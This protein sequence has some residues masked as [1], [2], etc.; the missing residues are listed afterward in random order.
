MS[1]KDKE[2]QDK[3]KK[4]EIAD[5]SNENGKEGKEGYNYL[6]LGISLGMIF[7]I[8]IGSALEQPALGISM[9]ILFGTAYGLLMNRKN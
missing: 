7:G 2:N 5:D 9:G 6:A 1:R 8:S 4:F 3:R